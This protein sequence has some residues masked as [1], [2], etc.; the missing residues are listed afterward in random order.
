MSLENIEITIESLSHEGRGIAAFKGKTLFVSGALPKETVKCKIIRQHRRYYEAQATEII[1]PSPDRISPACAHYTICGGCSLQ[2]V[3]N[4]A[5]VQLKQQALLDQLKH[6]GKIIPEE[7]LPPIMGNSF[8]YRRKARLGV[9]YVRKKEKLLIGFREKFSHYLAD[10]EEC[11]VLHPDVGKHMSKLRELI[12]SL[13]QYEHIPQIE[14]AVSDHATALVI[15]HMT[16]LSITDLSALCEFGKE[17]NFHIYLQPGSADSVHKIWP[18]DQNELLSY[19]LPDYELEM[20]FHPLDFTQVNGEINREMIAEAI[21]LLDPQSTDT[22]LDLFCGLGN[23]TLPIAR[24]AKNVTG[25]EGSIQMVNRAKANALLNHIHNA[26]FYAANLMEPLKTAPWLNTPY[27][28]ILLDPPRTGAKEIIPLIANQS[29]KSIVYVSCNPATLARDA[30]ELVYQH[31]YRL[32][33][34]GVINMFPHT[35]HIEAI[36]LFEKH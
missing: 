21:R 35:S 33:K 28:K 6:F 5:Q 24:F 15:R 32:K 19:F 11:E 22:I 10:I 29:A 12:R 3:D 1:T 8:G 2:H 4:Q 25:I 26:E 27:D 14:M 7:I 18:A 34:I 23:F 17:Q 20:Q 31:Q 30:G 36:A 9:R 16:S 13:S